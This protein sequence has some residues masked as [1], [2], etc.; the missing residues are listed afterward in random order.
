MQSV[1]RDRVDS[2]D[3]DYELQKQLTDARLASLT[4]SPSAPV[5]VDFINDNSEKTQPTEPA[6]TSES[7]TDVSDS[8]YEHTASG[9][10]IEHSY[11]D[12]TQQQND[13]SYQNGEQG[14]ADT[15]QYNNENVSDIQPEQQYVEYSTDDSYQPSFAET[16]VLIGS[17]HVADTGSEDTQYQQQLQEH[18]EAAQSQENQYDQQHQEQE[19]RR[20]EPAHTDNEY[21]PPP[22]A[23]PTP[24]TTRKQP[25]TSTSTTSPTLPRPALPPKPIKSGT[26]ATATQRTYYRS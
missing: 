2:V 8:G 5:S 22:K 26:D 1:T 16:E 25:D 12:Y 3:Y 17:G 11:D 14:T 15:Q 20:Q 24:P 7:Y 19:E 21:T 23:L 9:T 10:T 13:Y 4:G 6:Y 18:E